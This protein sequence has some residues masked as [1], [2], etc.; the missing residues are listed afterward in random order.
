MTPGNIQTGEPGLG[1]MKAALNSGK[2]VVTSNKSPL[3]LAFSELSGLSLKNGVKL[4][5]EATVGGA[6]PIINTCTNELKGNTILNIYGILNGTTNYIL[7]KMGEEG[8]DFKVALKEAQNLGFAEPDPSYDLKGVDSAAKVVILANSIFGMDIRISDLKVSGI[9]GITSETVELAS[10]YGFAIKLVGDVKNREV[11]P[12]LVALDHP[13]NVPGNLNAVLVQ[14]DTAG[15]ISL[16]GAGAG[17]K[18]TSS[19]IL[20]DVLSI[21][22]LL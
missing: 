14:T 17:P 22:D 18:E 12:R 15:D 10:E 6:I 13:L 9:E 16:I 4:K 8:I 7:S 21:A 5:F 3:S 1:F 19:A 11:S 20:G 2:H